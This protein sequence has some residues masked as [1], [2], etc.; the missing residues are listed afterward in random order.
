MDSMCIVI[1]KAPYGSL[2]AA[3]G[4]RHLVGAAA[5]G[6]QVTAVLVDD[7]V[8]V[9]KHGHDPD[10]TGWTSLSVIL[11][12][13]LAQAAASGSPRI[14]VYVHRP[15]AQQRGLGSVDFVSG[16][17]LVDDSQVTAALGGAEGLLVF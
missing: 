8:Y 1:R 3:E 10:D 4:V 9:A 13:A 14:Y 5:G 17:E 2:S 11:Q 12:Q 15:S 16:V 6:M 7:G